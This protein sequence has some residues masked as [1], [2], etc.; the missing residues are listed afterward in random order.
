MITDF[1]KV[2][3]KLRIDNG[4]VLRDM[5]IKLNISS[6][7]LSAIEVGKR[8]VPAQ[9]IEN[10]QIMYSLTDESV[11]QLRNAADTS[12]KS[13]NLNLDG[14]DGAKR[15]AALVFARN[16]ENMDSE[17]AESI[18]KLFNKENEDNE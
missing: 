16:L 12:M 1:G 5:A 10:L 14:V 7:Y 3:R 4:E 17:T 11:E 18:L 6:A 2:L 15:S 13:I 8:P 9:M